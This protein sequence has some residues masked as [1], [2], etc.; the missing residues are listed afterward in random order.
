[1]KYYA[2][3]AKYPQ[4]NTPRDDWQFKLVRP[5]GKLPYITNEENKESLYDLCK[6]HAG[7]YEIDLET[8]MAI[9][10]NRSWESDDLPIPAQIELKGNLLEEINKSIT[11]GLWL[12]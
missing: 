6:H 2:C 5:T 12:L 4:S 9:A 1:M 3:G 11:N 7:L 10:I 8:K